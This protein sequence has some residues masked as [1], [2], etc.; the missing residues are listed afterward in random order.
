MSITID[1]S[2]PYGERAARRLRDERIIWLTTVSPAGEPHPRPVWFLWD[3]DNFLIYSRPD[4]H[5]L[6][7]IENNPRVALSLDGDSHGGNIVVLTGRARIDH[8]APPAN[9]V[10]DYVTKYTTGMERIN[11]SPEQFAGSYSV[12]IRVE[13]N[14]L[15]GH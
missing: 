11:M 10:A 6:V 5:K 3:G 15:R 12:A 2:T 4:T 1:E 9:Q 14:R 7:H 13:P 8:T